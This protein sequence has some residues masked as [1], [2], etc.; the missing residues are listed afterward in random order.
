M[1]QVKRKVMIQGQFFLWGT[2]AGFRFFS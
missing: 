2:R 1:H